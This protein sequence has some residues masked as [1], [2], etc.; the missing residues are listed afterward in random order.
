MLSVNQPDSYVTPEIRYSGKWPVL[1]GNIHEQM[2]VEGADS[3]CEVGNRTEVPLNIVCIYSGYTLV[4]WP[5]L[6]ELRRSPFCPIFEQT[7]LC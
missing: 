3:D 1:D 2:I 6:C 4:E 7:P 5:T